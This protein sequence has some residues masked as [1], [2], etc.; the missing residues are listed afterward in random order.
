KE[1]HQTLPY[2]ITNQTEQTPSNQPP[3]PSLIKDQNNPKTKDPEPQKRHQ[4]IP[5]QTMQLSKNKERCFKLEGNKKGA[6]SGTF[7]V[8]AA[9]SVDGFYSS[10]APTVNA[11]SHSFFSPRQT[12]VFLEFL[13]IT[14]CKPNIFCGAANPL[15]VQRM[16]AR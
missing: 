11:P 2:M 14:P 9:R 15:C 7:V 1:I 12:R 8:A 6:V 5:S 16:D 13:R 3:S 4:R 10:P